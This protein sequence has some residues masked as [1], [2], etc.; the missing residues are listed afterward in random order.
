MSSLIYYDFKDFQYL[1]RKDGT[2]SK[3]YKHWCQSCQ[4]DRGYGFRNKII[5]ES[6]CHPCKMKSPEVLAK[7]SKSSTGRFV[8]S[9]TNAKKSATMYKLYNSSLENRKISRNLRSRLNKA[10][11]NDWK[12]GSAVSDLG[13]SID[14]LKAH[15]ESQFTDKM[16]WANYG[17]N[18]WHIDHIKPLCSFDLKYEVQLKEACRY[19]NLQP[20]W[21]NDNLRK[22]KID[23]TI[24]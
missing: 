23:G 15:L 20:L 13:C 6:L 18:G 24:K 12:S 8:S 11:T 22:R 17:R 2:K 5:K 7:I 16:S 4:K 21:W 10:I 19:T 9:E 1:I 3:Q 14:E